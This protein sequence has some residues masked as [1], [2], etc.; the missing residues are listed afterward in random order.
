L[1]W[2]AL[3][4]VVAAALAAVGIA[5]TAPGSTV[6]RKAGITATP[7]RYTEL[8]FV[9]P[10]RLPDKASNGSGA[11]RVPVAIHD[12]EGSAQTYRWTAFQENRDGRRRRLDS[13]EIKLPSD[14][15]GTVRPRMDLTCGANARVRAIVTLERPARSISYWVLCPGGDHGKF[16]AGHKKAGRQ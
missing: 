1:H 15:W 13:G 16:G 8:A 14:G 4:A 5:Q 2:L 10:A 7:T 3:G 9:S 12:A 6:L 11:W